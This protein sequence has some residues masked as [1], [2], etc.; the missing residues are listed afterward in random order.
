LHDSHKNEQIVVIIGLF[1]IKQQS[2]KMKRK[3]AKFRGKSNHRYNA[4]FICGLTERDQEQ[5]V[6]PTISIYVCLDTHRCN[7]DAKVVKG[8]PTLL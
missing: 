3:K 1:T 7:N 4:E 2:L 8:A 6:T 5:S